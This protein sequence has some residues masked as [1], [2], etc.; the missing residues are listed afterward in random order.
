MK[1]KVN[2]FISFIV[3]TALLLT[4]CS[5]A[6]DDHNESAES[7]GDA[8]GKKV[9]LTALITKHPLT[10]PLAEMEW[11]QKVEEAAGVEIEWQEITADW[12][13]K[14]G[15]MLASGDTP[16]LFIG[17]NV[18]TDADFAQF[19]GLF[20]DL[21]SMLDQAPNVQTMFNEKPDT[22]VIATQSDGKIY[23][24]PKYQRF[25]PASASRQFIN[26]QW[27]DNLGLGMPTTWDELYEVLVA[28]KEK[29]ANGNGNPNDEIP[30]D[31]PGGIGG[32]FNPAVLLGSMGITLT[33]GSGQGYFVE[34]GQVKNFLTDDRYKTMVLFLNKLYKAGLI[35]PEVFTH[36][37]TKYQ[38]IARGE[39][40]TAKVGFTWGWVASDR[41]GEQ[42][43]PQ[44]ASMP[45]LKA[46]AD[47]N[48]KLSWSYDYYSLNY[49][50]NHIVMSAKTKNKEAAM[51]FINELYA[52]EVGMQV[53][54]GSIGPNIKDNGDGTYAVLPPADAKMDPGTWKWTSTMA[55]NGAFYIPDSLKLTL[56]TDMQEVLGQSEP[57][58]PAL[59]VDPDKDVFPGM[60]IKYSTIDNNTMSLNNTNVMNLAESSF[61]KWVTKGGVE[62]EWDSYIKESQKAGL[63]QNLEIMQK[64]YD[65]YMN[66]N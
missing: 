32:Y 35:N 65:D 21:S 13:Q 2:V 39:G 58:E 42:L 59:E 9:K 46:F 28:F 23:G 56:G 10:K 1:K 14:K 62:A 26:Q 7:P 30:M 47:Y 61:A 53:L 15:T 25:W 51:R 17:P 37:Y 55:D 11:L 44:Y 24:L 27:L 49:G 20:Q 38:S 64:Y 22:K 43:A 54:F 29:D 36:D 19:Q 41:F 16:D 12:G 6:G 60:F 18:I 5:G 3:I 34:D 8:S 33:D 4:G 45:Q 52:P 50:P 66:Q 63:K 31:W 57:L 48:G 40:D